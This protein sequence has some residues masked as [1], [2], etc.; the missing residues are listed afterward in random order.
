MLSQV[1]VSYFLLSHTNRRLEIIPGSACNWA[2][3][4]VPYENSFAEKVTDVIENC[5]GGA[6]AALGPLPGVSLPQKPSNCMLMNLLWRSFT[7]RSRC[8]S[9]K[10]AFLRTDERG[11][12]VEESALPK[13]SR[14]HS[15][16]SVMSPLPFWA[17]STPL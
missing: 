1:I 15:S 14:N 13:Q 17:F 11:S 3:I 12:S 7:F 16:Q 9:Q 6:F 4:L 8:D 2:S 5:G 10:R